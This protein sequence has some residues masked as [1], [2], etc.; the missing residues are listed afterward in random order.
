MKIK[1]N[2][3]Y[4]PKLKNENPFQ[5]CKL[6][7]DIHAMNLTQIVKSFPD[8]FVLS[9]NNEWGAG[10]TTFVKMWQQYLSNNGFKTVYFN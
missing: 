9:I 7:R 5:N 4:I 8:G 6:G 2:D 1:H 10:K 3:L